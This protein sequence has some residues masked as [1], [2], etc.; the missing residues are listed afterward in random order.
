MYRWRRMTESQ[1]EQVLRDRRSNSRPWHGPAH[2]QS[3]TT[4]YLI[5]AA[6]YE[7]ISHINYDQ[8][9]I[10]DFQNQL[11]ETLSGRLAFDTAGPQ[12]PAGFL[13][14]GGVETRLTTE[15]STTIHTGITEPLCD[16][17]YAWVVL[18][19]H[20]HVLVQCRDIQRCLRELGKLHGRTSFYWNQE[21][22]TRG[23]QVWHRAAE[24]AMKSEGHFWATINYVHHNPVKHGYVQKWQDWPY[25]SAAQY[26]KCVGRER[27]LEIWRSFPIRNYGAKWDPSES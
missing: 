8:N 23:R 7:H 16:F 10:R 19:N 21:Q 22:V 15:V 24:T 18:P 20:Y 4:L 12:L 26:L 6:C 5:T 11:L 2:F 14:L 27:A 17:I 1:R 13:P 9:R 3:E 25:C